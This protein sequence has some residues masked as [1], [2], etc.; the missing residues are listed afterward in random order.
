MRNFILL[1]AFL[2]PSLL[3]S[4]SSAEK[5]NY[6]Q[7]LYATSYFIKTQDLDSASLVISKLISN[8]PDSIAPVR[9]KGDIL[10]QNF[11]L[12]HD[13]QKL[14]EANQTYQSILERD[15]SPELLRKI[16]YISE[17][18]QDFNSAELY[19]QEALKINPEHE[20]TLVSFIKCKEKNDGIG[21]A[22]KELDDRIKHILKP[23]LAYE[24]LAT[25]NNSINKSSNRDSITYT[26]INKSFKN[27]PSYTNGNYLV[28]EDI[29]SN[30]LN[31]AKQKL[32]ILNYY[33]PNSSFYF[34]HMSSIY[35]KQDSVELALEILNE[36]LKFNDSKLSC[37]L[38]LSELYKNQSN[39][40][41]EFE[42]LHS[43]ESLVLENS[44]L[45]NRL[46]KFQ[47]IL[48]IQKSFENNTDQ[49]NQ[50]A[51][52]YIELGYF[53]EAEKVISKSYELD[54]SSVQ[55]KRILLI[56]TY[57]LNMFTEA[58]ELANNL[59]KETNFKELDS[60]Y[61]KSVFSCKYMILIN[62]NRTNEATVLRK[63]ISKEWPELKFE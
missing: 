6:W 28:N 34:K 25:Y 29:S 30:R 60:D 53:N 1:L 5:N 50:I 22:E 18:R 8:Y 38:E 43:H 63:L 55:T 46:K 49:L 35:I 3:F 45:T 57:R 20:L 11:A 2:I 7:S 13:N 17:L 54:K 42:L 33:Y 36:G 62:L 40:N 37:V 10:L 31:A 16:A 12:S 27:A 26:L 19:Y 14:E 58:L 61:R 4:Q 59:I 15:K 44:I 41:K 39:I 9:L 32:S 52:N 24:L 23:T 51:I 21:I 47:N 56:N 48:A